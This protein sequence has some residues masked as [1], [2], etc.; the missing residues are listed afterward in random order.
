MSK[1]IRGK[2]TL[3]SKE[4]IKRTF[5]FEPVDRVAMG[6]DTN[7]I[8]HENLCKALKM[9]PKEKFAFLRYIGVDH[10]GAWFKYIGEKIYPDIPGRNRSSEHGAVTKYIQNQYGGYWDFCDFPLLDVDDEVIY[11]YPFPNPDDFDYEFY[12]QRVDY[13]CDM[14]FAISIGDPGTA[15]IM[16][17]TG[18]L[19]GVEQALINICTDHEA[20]LHMIDKRLN[21][22]LKRLER[23]L[24]LCKG[25]FDFM[26]L[27]E[28]LGSQHAPLISMDLYRR[29][30]KP[31]HQKFID[32][33]KAYNL[34]VIIHTCGSSSWVYEEFLEMGMNGVDTLQPEAKN[35]SPQYLT[36]H[37]GGRLVFRGC[38]S[39]AGPLAYGTVEETKKVC[40]ETLEI[41]SKHGGYIFAPTHAIQDNTPPE[42]TITMYNTAH[43]FRK[44]GK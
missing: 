30:L 12:K 44:K 4:R 20:T 3:S 29:V 16:N 36:D 43:A 42:N 35:M 17:T 41:M 19:M 24:E 14:G 1:I 11:N 9:D 22:Q 39:T 21:M 33:A 18:M 40:Q 6:Y 13:L 28:D 38:I 2:E 23:I 37:F 15:D 8:A 26:W 32:L 31:R 34:P 7:T 10:A 27:G 5:A 25:K